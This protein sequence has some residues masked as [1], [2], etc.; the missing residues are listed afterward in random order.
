MAARFT[1]GRACS[2]ALHC[3]GV[4]HPV[5]QRGCLVQGGGG[6]WLR[7]C[8]SNGLADRVCSVLCVRPE[9]AKRV[10]VHAQILTLMQRLPG[11]GRRRGVGFF[12]ITPF[13][14]TEKTIAAGC[15]GDHQR[16]TQ[17][18]DDQRA[19][20]GCLTETGHF[21][22]AERRFLLR[23]LIRHCRPGAFAGFRFPLCGGFFR[24]IRDRFIG[25]FAS[26]VTD[27]ETVSLRVIGMR[28]NPSFSI[29]TTEVP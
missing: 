9:Q 16:Q 15:Q 1:R 8:G 14:C 18:A 24:F 22:L 23:L 17:Q 6:R 13:Q 4:V 29:P 19:A 12:L 28:P 20:T 5:S 7:W 2:I 26:S 10:T 3:L 21:R 25:H 27:G 11:G